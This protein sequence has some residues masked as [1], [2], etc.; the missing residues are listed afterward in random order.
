MEFSCSLPSVTFAVLTVGQSV[1]HGVEPCPKQNQDSHASWRMC[2]TLLRPPLITAGLTSMLIEW[3]LFQLGIGRVPDSAR[4][5]IPLSAFLLRLCRPTFSSVSLI[6]LSHA[7]RLVY[8]CITYPTL[9]F[10]QLSGLNCSACLRESRA[11]SSTDGSSVECLAWPSWTT[12]SFLSPYPTPGCAAVNVFA[13]NLV[14]HPPSSFRN[15]YAFL[16]FALIAQ[17]FHFLRSLALPCTLVVPD[18][19]PRG[20]WWPLLRASVIQCCLLASKGEPVALRAS[21]S[22]NQAKFQFRGS[23]WKIDFFRILDIVRYW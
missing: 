16:P 6:F 15:P 17:L 3:L 18:I 13:Q 23:S 21:F 8:R 22:K 1:K 4:G 10:L 2:L 5:L 14:L 19:Y 9:L 12:P 11:I 7:T 20:F